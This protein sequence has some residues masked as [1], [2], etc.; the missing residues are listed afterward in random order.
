MLGAAVSFW[1]MNA[2]AKQLGMYH[3]LAASEIGFIRSLI[4]LPASI[5]IL[6]FS[7]ATTIL[8]D[9]SIW[10]HGWL[11][12]LFSFG[13][14]VC[15]FFTMSKIDMGD[16]TVL[17]FTS[18]VWSIFLGS[19]ILKEK[20]R[21]IDLFFTA[22]SLAGCVLVAHPAVLFTQMPHNEQD[23]Y[24][25][26]IA[27]G[28]GLLGAL[29]QSLSFITVRQVMLFAKPH[30]MQLLLHLS[31]VSLPLGFLLALAEDQTWIMPSDWQAWALLAAVGIAGVIGQASLAIGLGGH[32]G[33]AGANNIMYFQVV[34]AYIA[35][36]IIWHSY[37]DVY[38][39]T[40]AVLVFS[41]GI[42]GLVSARWTQPKPAPKKADNLTA[43]GATDH[44]DGPVIDMPV[45]SGSP[46]T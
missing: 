42:I 43:E 46:S 44:Q 22:L 25:R 39:T 17:S 20:I 29:C 28:V 3:G 4:S 27:I 8:G 36:M 1:T 14:L 2:S 24:W 30:P 34:L 7:S 40:G 21:F 16:A 38:S 37:P 11:R 26:P 15:I 19:L 45:V 6:H 31:I 18:P 35:D 32:A 33:V 41:C 12:G 10:L 5:L 23:N 13:A 9:K